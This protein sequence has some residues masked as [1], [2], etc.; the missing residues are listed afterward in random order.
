MRAVL[1]VDQ[2]SDA[3]AVRV[4]ERTGGNPFFL[5]QVCRTLLEE[6]AVT[7]HDGEAVAASGVEVLRLPDTV[8]A[9]IRARLDRLDRNSRDVLRVASVIGREFGRVL[10]GEV[11][12][13]G[14]DP[15]TA[16]DR[17]KASGLIQQT[18]VLPES[19]YRFRHVLTQEVA[20]D[21]LLERQRRSLHE[22]VGRTIERCQAN[23]ASDLAPLLAHHFAHAEA[24]REAVH[25]GSRAAERAASLTQF[26]DALTTLER[27]RGWMAHLPDD[28]ARTDALVDLLLH[29]ERLAETLG[30]RGRQQQ[31]IE[32][33]I[34]LLAPRG[35]SANLAQAYLRQGDVATLLKRFDAAERTLS[36]ALRLSRELGETAL[37]RY[38]LRS[39]GLLR[40]HQGRHAD[41]LAIARS[42]LAIAR[43]SSDD[44]MVAG[45]LVNIGIILKGMGDYRSALT[46]LEEALAIPAL[47]RNPSK[48][49]YALHSVGGV[50]RSLGDLDRA[51]VCLHRCDEIALAN[52]LP[53]P[54][55]FHLT[56]IAHIY[57]E[58]G[59]I[60]EALTTYR[61]AVELSQRAHHA[62]GHA[63]SLRALGDVLFGLGRNAEALPC[64]RHAARLFAQ[65]EDR[66]AG[67]E[68]VGR[69]AAILERLVS[70]A[71]AAEAWKT[72]A[73][74]RHALGDAR[75][76][77]D[78]LEGL[79]RAARQCAASPE[80]AIPAFQAALA[81]A[82]TLGDK[83]REV[84]LHNTIGIL[85]WQRERFSEALR[86][87]EVALG[88][89]REQGDRA[90]EGLL[91]NSLGV[92]LSRLHR[93][94]EARTALEE[95]VALN[96]ERGERLLE[97]HA[98]A[99]LG[100]VWRTRGRTE[101]AAACFEQSLALRCALGDR[102]GE[103]W[104]LLRL[105]E[106]LA[107]KGDASKARERAAEAMAIAEACRDGQLTD[108]CSQIP[109]VG[110]DEGGEESQCHDT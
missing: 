101:T 3:L 59:R 48:L 102:R 50:H 83:A 78:A 95:S 52:L 49:L 44:L 86:H 90:H 40:W 64:V 93:H 73:S 13:P 56:S 108:A 106:T 65:L 18:A 85:E 17:L 55:S 42:A 96:R 107:A 70:P 84:A 31:I 110:G 15:L 57:L 10:L 47:G 61:R 46:S 51:L 34:A 98:L 16:L 82:T 5:E 37:E 71:D 87:Y 100:D 20:Y 53:I 63:Q 32:E 89:V 36:T 2:V 23:R 68:M 35:A 39:I 33:L 25:Y 76:E 72:V 62:D 75:G 109:H 24:W 94:E 103:G 26:A 77:L 45:D 27:V 11:L 8:Q 60:D 91:L 43:E 79:A 7:T 28:D 41:A 38:A 69:S 29:Q 74:L 9:V 80:D 14:A 66:E 6:N 99:A 4:H 92:T 54:R 67:A 19:T 58:Q 12:G 81:L 22:V 104:M 21:S 88:L 30:L 1:R 97:A 105:A